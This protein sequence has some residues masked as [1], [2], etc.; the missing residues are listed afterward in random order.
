MKLWKHSGAKG[1]ACLVSYLFTTRNG[2]IDYYEIK[3][4]PITR[5]MV[6]AAYKEVRSNKSSSGIDGMTW[7]W[8]EK[9][10]KGE[11]YKL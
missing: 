11:L 8:L 3:S 4:Q 9:N 5:L 10:S 2:M 6:W 1:L 7:Q